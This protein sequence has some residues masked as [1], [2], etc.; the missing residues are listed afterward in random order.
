MKVDD[1]AS[2]DRVPLTDATLKAQVLE[3]AS[4]WWPDIDLVQGRRL[5]VRPCYP[6]LYDKMMDEFAEDDKTGTKASACIIEGSAGSGKSGFLL[7][8]LYRLCLLRR[9]PPSPARP[10]GPII[11][12]VEGSLYL[13][14]VDGSV[15]VGSSDCH[16]P[17]FV[18]EL[19]DPRSTYLF[20]VVE[21]FRPVCYQSYVMCRSVIAAQSSQRRVHKA[22]FR[23]RGGSRLHMPVW[24]YPELELLRILCPP[25]VS[26]TELNKRFAGRGGTCRWVD[27]VTWPK[28]RTRTSVRQPEGNATHAA[29]A[30]EFWASLASA[31]LRHYRMDSTLTPST[32][33]DLTRP[34]FEDDEL[35]DK[36]EA[37]VAA[38]IIPDAELSSADPS[39]VLQVLEASSDW[40]PRTRIIKGKRLVVRPCY[41]ALY[42]AMMADFHRLE[43]DGCT[44]PVT[45]VIDGTSGIGKS[46]FLFYVLYRLRSDALTASPPSP[47]HIIVH[48]FSWLIVFRADGSV[49]VGSR[50]RFHRELFNTRSYYLFDAGRGASPLEYAVTGCRTIVAASPSME[51]M[52]RLRM[53]R[54]FTL[55]MPVWTYPELEAFRVLCGR[56][57]P[58]ELNE[59]VGKWGGTVRWAVVNEYHNSLQMWNE[60]ISSLLVSPHKIWGVIDRSGEGR[61]DSDGDLLLHFVP[62][63]DYREAKVYFATSKVLYE[64]VRRHL[65]EDREKMRQ[66]IRRWDEGKHLVVGEYF[67]DSDKLA[68]PRLPW[69]VDTR[70]HIA[71]G[72]W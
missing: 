28:R 58:A 52:S 49:A 14:R 1:R 42:D 44:R 62:S 57:S 34:A 59:R 11:L 64:V 68:F 40:W 20:D 51:R 12:H 24:T 46:A 10:V 50:E 35:E 41:P 32:P 38:L 65:A 37:A 7:Y 3:A 47:R 33:I 26:P 5:I 25:H 15:A 67:Q 36:W 22:Y 48:L 27:E 60:A 2:K 17:A 54:S 72:G 21:D 61:D 30:E 43:T 18:K 13:F 69:W 29:D 6:Q 56:Q 4:D 9:A 45:C 39:S 70:A 71:S 63:A 53:E 66:H 55:Y 16:P 19:W 23:S 31:T 8:V